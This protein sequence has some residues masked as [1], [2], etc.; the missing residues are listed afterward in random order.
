MSTP[1]SSISLN[2]PIGI[3]HCTSALSILS[4]SRP[5]SKSSAASSKYGNKTRLTRKPGLSRTITGSFPTCRAK[6]SVRS[7]V[8]SE[9]CF[10]MTTSTSFIRLTGLKKWR[11]I[12][13]SGETVESASSPIGSAD[14]FV[15]IIV[16]GPACIA[17]S[18]KISFFI[19]IFSEA[20]S[21][22]NWTSRNSI[23]AVEATI[24]ARPSFAF[25]S[26]IKPRFTA[27][28]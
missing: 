27:S 13:C 6:A 5:L 18:Q 23:G 7:R 21:M 8:S 11:P 9:V 4:A 3:P 28:A 17:S 12:T 19:S 15:A 16:F 25:C 2:G 22:T 10:P 1:I 24:R 20:A 26:L 14:V